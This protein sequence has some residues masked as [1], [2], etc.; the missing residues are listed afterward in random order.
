MSEN[1]SYEGTVKFFNQE[2]R[3]GFITMDVVATDHF[4][5]LTGLIDQD[6][7]TGD[8][9]SFE[10]ISTDRGGKAINVRKI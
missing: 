10:L 5:H 2:K 4:V 7:T 3:F 6:I 1:K 8:K 9:V